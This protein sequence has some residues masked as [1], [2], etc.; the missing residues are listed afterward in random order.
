MVTSPPGRSGSRLAAVLVTGAVVWMAAPT[1]PMRWATEPVT[2][3]SWLDPLLLGYGHLHAPLTFA[4]A[5]VAGVA[6]WT[7]VAAEIPRAPSP[8]P[9]LVAGAILV[10][11]SILVSSY[12]W[13]QLLVLVLL[14]AAVVAGRRR[15][16]TTGGGLS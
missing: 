2:W 16:W 4:A 9:A 8:W 13:S 10:C 3:H 5:V 11:G 14:V 6:A 15:W 12:G 7:G 1:H